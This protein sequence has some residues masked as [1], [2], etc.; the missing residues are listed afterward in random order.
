VKPIILVVVVVLD[1]TSHASALLPDIL[2]VILPRSFVGNVDNYN[3]N[4]SLVG[5]DQKA[6]T[7]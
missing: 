7:P 1:T 3:R 2:V 5:A 6:I 4:A